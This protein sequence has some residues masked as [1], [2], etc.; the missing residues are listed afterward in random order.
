VRPLPDP[1]RV[2]CNEKELAFIDEWMLDFNGARAMLRAGITSK[3][4]VARVY[5][6][7]YLDRPHVLLEIARRRERNA[8]RLDQARERMIEE[9]QRI[10][11]TNIEDVVDWGP[12]GL[13]VRNRAALPHEHKA[14][15]AEISETRGPA[16]RTIRVKMHP[17]IE[18]ITQFPKQI[19]PSSHEKGL[20]DRAG[21]A[22][23]VIEGGPTGL[24]VTVHQSESQ[25]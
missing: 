15:I 8:E 21:T 9:L 6:S 2:A 3:P 22:N 25:T 1:E 19:S 20:A 24:E 12:R 5:A 14:A 4:Q 16:G 17:K 11:L 13:V 7:V 23:I 10:A 18:A